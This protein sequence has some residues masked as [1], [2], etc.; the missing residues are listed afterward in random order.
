MGLRAR[1]TRVTKTPFAH[2]LPQSSAPT[3]QY[4]LMAA[5][6][7]LI[8]AR[9]W[10]S[11]ICAQSPAIRPLAQVRTSAR[12]RKRTA[13]NVRANLAQA[14][15]RG[16]RLKLARSLDLTRSRGIDENRRSQLRAL[17]SGTINAASTRLSNSETALAARLDTLTNTQKRIDARL[18]RLETTAGALQ[19]IINRKP[20]QRPV[21][22]PESVDPGQLAPPTV[23]SVLTG[24][25]P[26][27]QWA[28][29]AVGLALLVAGMIVLGR[30]WYAR[31]TLSSRQSRIEQMLEQARF[32]AAPLLE[33]PT[34]QPAS[35]RS[36]KNRDENG[37]GNGAK[38]KTAHTP[39][40]AGA[41]ARQGAHAA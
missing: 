36:S 24:T 2:L 6:A 11:P 7:G 41:R 37:A 40:V 10:S 13:G 19:T 9:S 31:R 26:W 1:F 33:S 5:H 23:T 22:A 14:A 3:P 27:S 18:A 4:F 28:G 35:T 38:G 34:A 15:P 20:E 39:G 17:A 25:R 16:L 8:S 12:T 29:I 21:T 32:E 30:K